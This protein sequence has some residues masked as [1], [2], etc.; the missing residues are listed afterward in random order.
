M[1]TDKYRFNYVSI[2]TRTHARHDL[3]KRPVPNHW[4]SKN[5]ADFIETC[6]PGPIASRPLD[7]FIALHILHCNNILQC[8]NLTFLE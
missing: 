8:S 2:E 4:F 3:R 1:S 7:I 6:G 5:P